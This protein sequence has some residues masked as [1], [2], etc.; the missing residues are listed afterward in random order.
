M[1]KKWAL[2]LGLSFFAV[3][4]M[5]SAAKTKLSAVD[6]DRNYAEGVVLYARGDLTTALA[7]FKKARKRH[8]GDRSIE[9]AIARARADLIASAMRRAPVPVEDPSV[10]DSLDAM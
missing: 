2:L 3:A 6:S 8:P 10:M 7:S 1:P 5:P 4:A 9:A